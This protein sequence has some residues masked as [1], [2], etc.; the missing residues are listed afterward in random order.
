VK[1][2]TVAIFAYVCAATRLIA[3]QADI[4]KLVPILIA[5]E[6]SGN[7]RAIGPNGETGCLQITSILLRDIRRITGQRFTRSDTF[8]RETSCK[9]AI[10]Y[11]THY[12][13]EKRLKRPPTMRDYAM[14]WRYGPNGWKRR[15]P[16]PYWRKV[17]RLLPSP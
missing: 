8:N 16:D 10:I 7:D 14:V 2:F 3:G 12:V 6:S 1:L 4:E 9:I 5:V 15:D 11:L 17:Q 13:N